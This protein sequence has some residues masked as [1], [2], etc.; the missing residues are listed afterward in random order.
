M[1][2]RRIFDSNVWR[3]MPSFAAAPEGPDIRPWLSARA[4]SIVST[5]RF[6]SADK[7]SPRDGAA[8]DSRFS[9]A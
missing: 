6:S 8:A 3:G 9:Q 2:S 1:P 7:A 5:S 4:A